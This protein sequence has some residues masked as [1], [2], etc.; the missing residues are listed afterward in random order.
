[1]SLTGK[2]IGAYPKSL[3]GTETKTKKEGKLTL[4]GEAFFFFFFCRGNFQKTIIISLDKLLIAYFFF[5]L[6]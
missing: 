3:P 5:S 2:T 4:L 6:E 1:M